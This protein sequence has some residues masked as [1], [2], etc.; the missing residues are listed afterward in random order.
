M[1]GNWPKEALT[2]QGLSKERVLGKK[3]RRRFP[4]QAMG[5]PPCR[6][7]Q[8]DLVPQLNCHAPPTLLLFLLLL[9][10]RLLGGPEGLLLGHSPKEQRRG[11]RALS[12]G[13]EEQGTWRV[14]GRAGWDW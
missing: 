14:L 11:T 13:A 1:L 5:N 2:Y 9:A 7:L 4:P 12:W 10:A 8:G 3:A 6:P